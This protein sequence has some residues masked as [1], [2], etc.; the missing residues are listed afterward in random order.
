[1]N[2]ELR[3]DRRFQHF[4][5][6]KLAFFAERI[7]RQLQQ[8]P[9]MSVPARL[10]EALEAELS[11]FQSVLNNPDLKR[12]ARTDAIRAAE[13]P[14][15]HI[16]SDLACYVEKAAPCKSDIYTTGFRPAWEGRK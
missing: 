11:R 3:V 5:N 14:L 6:Q 7:L 9:Y 16:L 2:I 4:R 15:R 10:L 8:N 12:K 13:I 1:M